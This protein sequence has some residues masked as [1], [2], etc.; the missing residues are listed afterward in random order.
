MSA[1]TISRWRTEWINNPVVEQDKH[2]KRYSKEFKEKIF[3]ALD[4]RGDRT[5]VD[6]AKEFNIDVKV[7]YGFDKKRG[8]ENE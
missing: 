6:I 4:N 8:I 1:S 7:V 3:H 5:K 2:A